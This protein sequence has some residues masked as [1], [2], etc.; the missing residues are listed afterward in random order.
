MAAPTARSSRAESKA[1]TRRQILATA[2]EVFARDG[3]HATSLD[4]IAAE[5]GFTKGA[6]YSTFASKADLFLALLDE[7]AADRRAAMEAAAAAAGTPEAFVTE[8]SRAFAR[9]A[10]GERA[11]WAA[12]IEFIPVVARDEELRARYARHHDATREQIAAAIE[13]WSRVTG[14]PLAQPARQ[15]ATAVLGAMNGL[16]LE[17]MLAPGE[18]PESLYVDSQLAMLAGVLGPPGASP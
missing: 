8:V 14:R 6:V 9:S 1:R 12:I 2:G 13:R 16:T 5:A 15:F 7:R 10:V 11:W 17:A 4:R 18:V 3:Y